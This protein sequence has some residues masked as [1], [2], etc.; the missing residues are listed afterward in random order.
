MS[1]ESTIRQMKKMLGN[2]DKLLD[3]AVAFAEKKKIDPGVLLSSRLTPDQW[4]L[5]RQIQAACDAPKYAAARLAGKDPPKHPDTETTVD[6]LHARIKAVVEYLDGFKAS[7]FAGADDRRMP[8]NFMEG[9]TLSADDYLNELAVPNFYFHV[10][11][12]YSILRHNGVEIG[13]ND[14]LGPLNVR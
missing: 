14:Y 12:A 11:T 6:E 9:K 7:D 3:A 4:P 5:V 10:A 13:K 8:L 1:Y 2:L